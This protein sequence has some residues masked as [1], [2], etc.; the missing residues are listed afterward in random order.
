MTHLFSA[1][2]SGYNYT[3][4][5]G[6]G[7]PCRTHVESQHDELFV[8]ELC[9]GL[10]NQRSWLDSNIDVFHIN[11]TATSRG[12]TQTRCPNVNYGL[13]QGWSLGSSN[14]EMVFLQPIS[15][16]SSVISWLKLSPFCPAFIRNSEYSYTSYTISCLGRKHKTPETL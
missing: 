10:K 5:T 2:Y 1:I 12:L 14:F 8:C 3:F 6:K 13:L 16:W 7:P 4:I 15:S 11:T 9:G